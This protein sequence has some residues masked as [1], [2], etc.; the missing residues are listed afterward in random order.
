[1]KKLFSCLVIVSLV[2]ATWGCSEP[3]GT[4]KGGTGTGA[5]GTGS[6]SESQPSGG[7]E[8]ASSGTGGGTTTSGE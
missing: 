5:G 4:K 1:M 6:T 8:P 2:V 3:S 7:S